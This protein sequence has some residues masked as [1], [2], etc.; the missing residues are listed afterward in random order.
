MDLESLRLLEAVSRLGTV[1][2]AA[3]ELHVSQPALSRSLA[4]LEGR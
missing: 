4:R 3:H 2:A 1:T